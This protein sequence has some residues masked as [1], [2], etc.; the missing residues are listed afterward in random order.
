MEPNTETNTPSNAEHNAESNNESN[1]GSNTDPNTDDYGAKD[2][3]VLTG[4]SAV[5]KRPA[6]YIGSTGLRGLHHLV[7]EAVDNSIDEALAGFCDKIAVIIHKDNSV[8]VIDNG[9]GIPVDIHPKYNKSAV[10]IVM[11]KLHAGGKFDKKTYKVSGGLHGVGISV[12]NAL[13]KELTV[14]V[15]RNR[16]VYQQK[17]SRGNPITE[18]QVIGDCNDRGTKVTFL[19]DNEIFSETEFH[20]DTLSSRLRELAFLNKGIYITLF[21]ERTGKKQEFKY[22]GGIISFV[23]FLNQNKN[24]LHKVIYF[25]KEKNMVKI[26]LAMQ[27]NMGYQENIFTFANNINTQ[28]G[29]SH[30]I[31]FKTALTRTMNSYAEKLKANDTKMSSDDVREGLT[32]VIS[33]QLPEPQFEGQTKTKLGN[34]E[35]KGIVES[36]VNEN[37]GIFLE[38]NPGITKLI[39]DKCINSAKAREAAAKARE[40]TRRKG[41]LNHHSMPGKLADCSER[42]PAKCELYIVE[43]DSAGGCFSG[44]TKVA[45]LN[46]RNLSFKELVEEDKKGKRN[47]CY[48]INQDGNLQI[49]LIKHPRRTR[50]NAEVLKIV[51]DNDKEIICTP[52][53]KFMLRDGSYIKAN[54]LK[55]SLSLMPLNRKSSQIAGRIAIKDYEMVFNP[56]TSKWKFTHILADDFNIKNGKYGVEL[57]DYRHHIDFN[58]ANNNPENIARMDKK[59]HLELHA[60]ILEKTLLR[61]DVQQKAIESHKNPE[62]RKKISRIMSTPE[63][64]DML[65][66]RAKK[67]WEDGEYKKFMI[68]SFKEFYENNKEYRKESLERLN[69]LQKEYWSKEDNRRQQS[70]RTKNYFENNNEAREL[71]SKISSE[72]W[73]NPELRKWRS[74]KTK[75]QWTNEFRENRKKAY[76]KTYF[77][78]TIKFMKSLADTKGTLKEYDRERVKSRNKNLLKKETFIERFFNHDETA[79]LEAVDNYNHKIKKIIKLDKKIDVY[80]LEVEGTHNFAL[81]SGIFVHNSAKQGRNR[82]FQAILPLKG[83][84]LNVEKARLNKIFQNEEIITMITALGTGISEEFDA[85]KI[86]YH[87]IIIMTDADVDG[88]HIRTLL[89]TFFY[90]HMNPL[91]TQGHIYIAQPPLYKVGKNK[92]IY[93]IYSD[94]KLEELFKEIGRD[95]ASVQRYKGLGEMNPQQLWETTMDPGNRTLLQVSLEDAVEAD[96]IFTILMGDQ[97]EPRRD[98]IQQHAKEVANLDI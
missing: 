14:E 16:K 94:E 82:D 46:G 74:E 3:Q 65:S 88:A 20:F 77:E 93:Y 36:L 11:T 37:L 83:K 32:T 67:Q 66:K 92:K 13:S 29:G 15:M 30:L 43:G 76:N 52:D 54:E 1:I 44:D 23:E 71:L 87:K 62:F 95:N 78:N 47:Y 34:S 7:F 89:L 39:V 41:A 9:R 22:D 79:M 25:Q 55:D 60:K 26:E 19:P 57:G 48:T 96:K 64:K 59:G 6:M 33:V 50:Q 35:V 24:P 73:D 84:I 91:I 40:L 86:R 31:G 69:K 45:L 4:L 81:E 58:K 5:R 17:Y 61:K 10:E 18:L 12:A 27:Y 56:L 85:A 63:M 21:D 8:T 42:D 51:L 98:F 72:Q 68:K 2:I 97:V 90:R 80:D 75:E 53:H 49:G 70:E 38:E 28:E